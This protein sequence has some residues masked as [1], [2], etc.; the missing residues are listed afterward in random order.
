M[1][2]QTSG[3]FSMMIEASEI[4]E[5]QFDYCHRVCV[6]SAQGVYIV[7]DLRG[8]LYVGRS[9]NL[10]KRFFDHLTDTHNPD[11][12]ELLKN[13]QGSMRFSWLET[14]SITETEQLEKQVIRHL[15]PMCNKIRY[16]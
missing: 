1:F 15:K 7:H 5:V 12:A 3:V 10:N 6:P 14:T 8:P 16:N 9:Q 4:H 13:P 2:L 11:F